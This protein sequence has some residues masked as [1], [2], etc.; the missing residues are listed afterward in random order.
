MTCF[1][2]Q[3]GSSI[4]GTSHPPPP[5]LDTRSQASS[6]CIAAQR[7]MWCQ[8]GPRSSQPVLRVHHF[9]ST[10]GHESRHC[11]TAVLLPRT[12][13]IAPLGG[14]SSVPHSS[15][16]VLS[17]PEAKICAR[18]TRSLPLSWDRAKAEQAFCMQALCMKRKIRPFAKPIWS[19]WCSHLSQIIL[20]IQSGFVQPVEFYS[21]PDGDHLWFTSAQPVA[22]SGP[23]KLQGIYLSQSIQ[24][25]E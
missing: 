5:L 19:S 3:L 25:V 11:S 9:I 8:C 15:T 23:I 17:N 12:E 20:H 22:Q 7:S 14:K 18:S 24:F 16:A 2:S 21:W 13:R 1:Q 4:P 6:R 10:V